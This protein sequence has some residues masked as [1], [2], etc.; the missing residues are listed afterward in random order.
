MLK[1]YITIAL[2]LLVKHKIFSLI[3]ILG[4]STGIACCILISL[5]V[6][7]EFTY[8]KGFSEN[9]KVFRINTSF[10]REGVIENIPHTSPPI[11]PGLAQA[12]PEVEAYTRV[13]EPLNTEINIVSYKDKS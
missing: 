13:M 6:Q 2:R 8:E 10:N 1:N 11:A 12:L 3:N 9:E 5:Y 4:L 7:D